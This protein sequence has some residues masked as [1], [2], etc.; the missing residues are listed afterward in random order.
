M[1]KELEGPNRRS[2]SVL[3]ITVP[4][5]LSLNGAGVGSVTSL[6][7]RKNAWQIS[8]GVVLGKERMSAR[9][10]SEAWVDSAALDGLSLRFCWRLLI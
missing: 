3:G 8:R 4:L 6:S 5:S 7:I 9:L 2:G 10:K 1:M